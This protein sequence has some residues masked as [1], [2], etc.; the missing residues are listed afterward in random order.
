MRFSVQILRLMLHFSF[1]MRSTFTFFYIPKEKTR[2]SHFSPLGD[3]HFAIFALLIFV[4]WRV[5]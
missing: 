1:T 2:Q 3:I 5:C 4:K